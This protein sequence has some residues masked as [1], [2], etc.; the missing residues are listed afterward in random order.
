[1]SWA[2]GELIAL[3]LE[4]TSANPLEALPVS[5][6]LLHLDDGIVIRRRYGLIRPGV[7]IPPES[8]EIHG[9]TD[10]MV[11][12]RGGALAASIA[13]LAAALCEGPP[14][15]ACNAAY[16]ITVIDTCFRRL[17]PGLRAPA[18]EVRL[19]DPLVIDRHCDKYRKGSRK[20]TAL[21]ATY[22]VPY[23]NAH[24]AG[25]DAEA[26][27]RVAFAIAEK[28]PEVGEADIDLLHAL[29]MGWHREFIDHLSDYYVSQGK[30]PLASEERD[31][32]VRGLKGVSL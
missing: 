28:Y 11:E 13:G 26:A 6:A 31:W 27:A 29:E 22:G 5:F 30:E 21:C 7:P 10:D 17:F 8:T 16:D 19:I 24:H 18:E 20:L 15:V 4:A 25:A 32:P 9:I 3:D 2:D 23:S 12:E 1:L 14:V